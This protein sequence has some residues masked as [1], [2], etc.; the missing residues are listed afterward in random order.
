MQHINCCSVNVL[1]IKQIFE[2]KVRRRLFLTFEINIEYISV[3]VSFSKVNTLELLIIW[4]SWIIRLVL[5]SWF[6]V[7]VNFHLSG[8]AV[9]T[10][11]IVMKFSVILEFM[12]CFNGAIWS[13]RLRYIIN[14][15]HKKSYYIN[16]I[17]ID[18]NI[19]IAP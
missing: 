1:V 5:L 2:I 10:W 9:I 13:K 4:W 17:F 7:I 3:D 11:R 15:F 6:F 8:I 14:I 16:W 19:F 18:L 12:P